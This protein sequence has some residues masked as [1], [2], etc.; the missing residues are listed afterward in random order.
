MNYDPMKYQEELEAELAELRRKLG[1]TKLGDVGDPKLRHETPS[2]HYQEKLDPKTEEFFKSYFAGLPTKVSNGSMK[3]APESLPVELEDP[4]EP[5]VPAQREDTLDYRM[6]RRITR[7]RREIARLSR[8]LDAFQRASNIIEAKEL[9]RLAREL[10]E[11]HDPKLRAEALSALSKIINNVGQKSLPAHINDIL[12][13][14]Q[15]LFAAASD[16]L[17]KALTVVGD[18]ARS[19]S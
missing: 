7:Q 16:A 8:R 6:R 17:D 13:A 2:L 3:P 4:A 11:K 19:R 10:T 14:S 5:T 15:V 18:T 1:D 12:A 9:Y